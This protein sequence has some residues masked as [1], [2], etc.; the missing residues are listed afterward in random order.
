MR[1]HGTALIASTLALGLSLPLTAAK[2]ATI[3]ELQDSHAQPV[4]TATI[5][6]VKTGGIQIALDLKNLPPGEHAVHL[7]Q[8]AT[9]EAPSFERAGPHFNPGMKQHGLNNPMG[10]HAGDMNNFIVASNGTAKKTILNPRVTMETGPT[11]IFSSGGTSLL[12]HAKADDMTSD[13]AG[14]AGDRIACGVIR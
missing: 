1:V 8:V 5:S 2:V 4:G 3:V 9:C 10:P 14:N 6:P 11:S 13:P 12:V 7:H